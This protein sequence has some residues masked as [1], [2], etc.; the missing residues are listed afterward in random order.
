MKITVIAIASAVCLAGILAAQQSSK[1]QGP[2]DQSQ[3]QSRL[4]TGGSGMQP[5][6]VRQPGVTTNTTAETAR[7][8][9]VISQWREKPREVAR[10]TIQKYG[11]PHEVSVNRLIWHR[12]GPWKFT[13]LVNEEIDHNFPMPHKDMLR[14]GIALDVPVEKFTELATYD[15]SVIVER[16]KG[17]L[18]A[19][20]DQEEMNFLA[21]NLAHD[22]IEGKITPDEARKQYAQTVGRFLK[23]ERPA[24]TT[25]LHFM[26]P[27]SDEA[28]DPD[29]P[30]LME[31]VKGWTQ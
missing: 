29:K 10:K 12:S 8:E 24:Y 26:R 7:V 20:C 5:V 18:S 15:G 28:G 1:I 19:R 14:Q 6:D 13:E 2:T 23:G 31:G 16:T 27:V 21:I 4:E 3:D 17:E 25:G 22:I 9:E 11:Q 30:M